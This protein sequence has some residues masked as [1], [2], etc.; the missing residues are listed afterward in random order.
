MVNLSSAAQAPVTVS[1]L[2]KPSTLSDGAVYAQSKLAIT[3]WTEQLARS[4]GET[5]PIIVA[6]NPASMLG[7]K[8][9]KQAYGVAGGDLNRGAD[10]LIR[11]SFSAEFAD[12]SGQYFDNDI[13]QF[14]APHPDARNAQKNHELMETL[15]K[16]IGD[17]L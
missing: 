11:A 14:R 3:M 2:L 16:L 4:L 9:V 10:I 6:V 17:Y 13:G 5:G 8:M 12:A 7:S 1:S 15:D